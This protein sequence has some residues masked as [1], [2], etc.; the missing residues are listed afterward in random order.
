MGIY[1]G[2][3]G[4]FLNSMMNWFD[5]EPSL[6]DRNLVAPGKRCASNM[7]PIQVFRNGKLFPNDRP[8]LGVDFDPK[9]VELINVIDKGSDYDHPMFRRSD[10]SYT[11]W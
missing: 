3:T 8:G 2:E 11:N 7:S 9:N 1:A 6:N 4:I 5:I 10:G